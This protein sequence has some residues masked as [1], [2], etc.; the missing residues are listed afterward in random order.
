MDLQR[1]KRNGQITIPKEYR[2]KFGIHDGDYIHC[3]AMEDGI[4]VR[5]AI[6]IIGGKTG[7]K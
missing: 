3:E 6:V 2:E 7:V 5:K 4:L 1:V